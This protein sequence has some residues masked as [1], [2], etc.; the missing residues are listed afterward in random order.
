MPRNQCAMRLEGKTLTC[1]QRDTAPIVFEIMISGFTQWNGSPTVAHLDSFLH[2]FV[3]Q[4]LQ[5]L[6]STCTN[7]AVPRMILISVNNA[8]GTVACN[9]N[10]ETCPTDEPVQD[11][12]FQA[13][14]NN[15]E[16]CSYP[17]WPP[18]KLSTFSFW[19]SCDECCSMKY[20][21]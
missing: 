9:C 18:P 14:M 16:I 15:N 1:S 6:V 20:G 4:S 21:K 3:D 12:F 5:R 2:M 8:A 7:C 17:S 10:G 19:K 13:I 11:K